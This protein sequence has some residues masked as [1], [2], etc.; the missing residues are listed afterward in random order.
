[1]RGLLLVLP[2][3]SAA[4]SAPRPNVLVLFADD[5][6]MGDASCYGHPTIRTPN[7]DRLAVEGIRFT[8]WYSGFHVCSPSRA[9]MMTGRLPIRTGCAG[10]SWTGGVFNSDAVGGLPTNE[11]TMADV[12]R[13]AGCKSLAPLPS[14]A[15]VT[16]DLNPLN[17]LSDAT[18]AAGKWHLGQ[19]K[20]FLPTSRGFDEYLG[21]PYSVDMGPS[22]WDLYTSTDRP[23]L[24]LLRNT[25]VLEQP[26]DLNKLSARYAAFVSSFIA[27]QTAAGK[28]W[29]AYMAFNHVHVPD[30]ATA[31]FCNSSRRGRFGDAIEEMDSTLGVI[32]S[33]V[34]DAGADEN[35]IVFFTSGGCS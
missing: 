30:F 8:Q 34:K 12:L 21:I 25:K 24:P 31:A 33:A 17:A 5:M 11:T 15:L 7:I 1:M 2:L 26:T 18:A 19:Q 20:Q 6:G 29:F 14:S 3:L 13:S 4:S 9:A 10:A 28:P 16:S 22:P 23:P 35:T 32:M 27:N